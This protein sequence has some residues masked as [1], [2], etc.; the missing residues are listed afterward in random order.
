M[1]SSSSGV[2][3][4][5]PF[6]YNFQSDS[7]STRVYLTFLSPLL[8]RN[9]EPSAISDDEDDYPAQNG[10][11][12]VIDDLDEDIP[13]VSS[14]ASGSLFASL[15]SLAASNPQKSEES[16]EKSHNFVDE[17][18]DLSSIPKANL[19]EKSAAP[20]KPIKKKR[21]GKSSSSKM[22]AGTLS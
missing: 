15:P 6:L 7:R 19:Q 4:L 9:E 12:G 2:R 16:S 13:G 17:E 14:T 5:G 3:R 20:I 22:W 11:T 18:E 21:N 10:L 1:A 8:E